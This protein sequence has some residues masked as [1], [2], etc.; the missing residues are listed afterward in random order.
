MVVVSVGSCHWER[1][2]RLAPHPSQRFSTKLMYPGLFW[3]CGPCRVR[4][5]FFEMRREQR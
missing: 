3:T 5:C 2:L 1:E 4:G